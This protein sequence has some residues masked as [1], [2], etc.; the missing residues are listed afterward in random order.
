[1]GLISVNMRSIKKGL[2][3]TW[4]FGWRHSWG[5]SYSVDSVRGEAGKIITKQFVRMVQIMQ[6]VNKECVKMPIATRR[7]GF[8]GVE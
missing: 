4:T 3:G 5:I 6:T 8:L 1:M 7:I 2:V